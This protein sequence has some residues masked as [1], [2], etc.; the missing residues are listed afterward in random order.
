MFNDTAM[1]VTAVTS[2]AL[3]GEGS[4]CLPMPLC[5]GRQ[6]VNFQLYVTSS[7]TRSLHQ[8]LYVSTW[9]FLGLTADGSLALIAGLPCLFGLMHSIGKAL[10]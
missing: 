3:C 5:T 2:I 8:H 4:G 10:R 1:S 9:L 6:T 7:P